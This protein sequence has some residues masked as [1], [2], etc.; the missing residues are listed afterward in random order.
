MATKMQPLTWDLLMYPSIAEEISLQWAS[1][2][3]C[4]GKHHPD[5]IKETDRNARAY[6]DMTCQYCGE[7]TRFP[8]AE[9]RVACQFAHHLVLERNVPNPGML[10]RGFRCSHCGEIT[11]Y[12]DWLWRFEIRYDHPSIIDRVCEIGRDNTRDLMDH[13]EDDIDSFDLLFEWIVLDDMMARGQKV[14]INK[15]LRVDSIYIRG[16]KLNRPIRSY[17]FIVKKK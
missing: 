7:H 10:V 11:R 3:L 14:G 9:Y 16:A 1:H 12:S 17:P 5:I 15:N 8:V 13:Y 4:C 6:A 2:A